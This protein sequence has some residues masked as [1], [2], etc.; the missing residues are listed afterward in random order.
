M[1]PPTLVNVRKVY[2]DPRTSTRSARD[3]EL[4]LWVNSEGAARLFVHKGASR[5]DWHEVIDD[6]AVLGGGV[7]GP[8]GD[9]GETGA[10]GVAGP[11]GSDGAQGPQGP[12][13]EPGA[14]GAQGPTGPMGPTGPTG[15]QGAKG[16]TGDQG[17]QGVAGS[18]GAQGPQGIQGP[19]GPA[20]SNGSTGPAG[21]APAGTGFV[22]VTDGV[23][24]T[25]SA[26]IAQA[27][28]TGLVAAL[29]AKAASASLAAVATSGSASDLSTGTL[30]IARVADGDI[31]LAKIQ[32]LTAS[33]ILGSSAGG[34]PAQLTAAQVK[35]IL[36]ISSSDVS[37]LVATA[38]STDAANLTGTLAAARIADASLPVAK[39]TGLAATATSTDAAGLTGT[40]AAARI[41]AG[42][43]ALSK[44]ANTAA[45]CIV[46]STAAGVPAELTAAQAKSVLAITAADVANIGSSAWA[47]ARCTADRTTTG[48]ALADIADLSLALLASST[49]EFE[50]I[51]MV[52]SSS[53]AGNQ[54][55]VQFSAAGATVEAM[56]SG[57]LAAATSRA[58]RI[59]AL[60]T[61]TAAY[62][63]S[64]AAGGIRVSGII[65]IG[66]NAGNLTLRHL[67]VT[68]GTSTVR[69]Q[70]YMRAIKIA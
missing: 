27:D 14:T 47:Y 50:A 1:P 65:V 22:K 4:V 21:P 26:A 30:P 29:A 51:L 23:L 56:I 35:T 10:Q 17:P 36:A 6:T 24:D 62:V 49:Y 5:W 37:G 52:A 44:L 2:A 13:G 67:K 18:T 20:G 40:L 7:Q 53:T 48:Q 9:T 39:V 43:L 58:D 41:A 63:T 45:A 16:D 38:T 46:G 69:A 15:P 31:T 34:A 28:V 25:P 12:Q 68:S 3:G 61:A 33:R 19:Q 57:T 11:A 66:A 70:S 55:G 54:Y 8:K 42:S 64:G 32:A 59:A 60:N